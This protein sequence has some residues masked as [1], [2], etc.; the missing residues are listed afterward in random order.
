MKMVVFP[1]G[2]FQFQVLFDIVLWKNSKNTCRWRSK[3]VF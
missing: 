1:V 2:R 3:Q